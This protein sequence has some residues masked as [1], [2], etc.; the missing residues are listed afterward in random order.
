[1]QTNLK[2]R[3][4][5]FVVPAFGES[6][7]LENCLQCLLN[8]SVKADIVITS[9]RENQLLV[10][11]A[12]KYSI[13]LLINEK[14]GSISRDWDFA[15]NVDTN[16]LVTLAHQDDLYHPEYAEKMLNFFNENKN[17]AIAFTDLE[18]LIN[19]MLYKNNKRESIKKILRF[20]AYFR[21]NIASSA[22]RHYILLGFGCSIPCPTVTYNKDV[23]GNFSFSDFYTVNL[24]WDAWLR[25]SKNKSPI[26]YIRERLVTHRIHE[27]AETQKGISEKRREKEDLNLFSR[28]WPKPIARFLLSL[29]RFSY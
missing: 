3:K 21:L 10:S 19:G 18:E 8:Q 22:I 9:H 27:D 6:P 11:L 7:Y 17:C 29:Y 15:L 2:F 23:I 28:L 16:P 20:L 5:T 12:K 1:M 26:G 4:I 25:L 24:D 13:P 14:G